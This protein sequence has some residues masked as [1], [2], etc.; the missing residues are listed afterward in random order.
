MGMNKR[1]QRDRVYMSSG[2][3]EKVSKVPGE[4]AWRKRIAIFESECPAT[5]N[6]R[7]YVWLQMWVNLTLRHRRKRKCQQRARENAEEIL[8][9]L[10]R[11]EVET[12]EFM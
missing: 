4:I 7:V 1:K 9:P 10:F 12:P 3:A 8:S 6:L 2:A 11:P 5:E